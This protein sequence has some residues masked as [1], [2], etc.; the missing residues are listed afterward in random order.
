ME[1]DINFDYYK[2]FMLLKID[3]IWSEYYSE[4]V[5]ERGNHDI[6]LDNKKNYFI[7]FIE[8]FERE[9]PD[10]LKEIYTDNYEIKKDA[11]ITTLIMKN[12]KKEI[13]NKNDNLN[14]ILDDFENF[15]NLLFSIKLEKL[16]E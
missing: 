15:E 3:D 8:K 13:I 5:K 1:D 9:W 11:D 12:L 10:Y 16:F 14:N 7:D 4:F 6:V 2:N